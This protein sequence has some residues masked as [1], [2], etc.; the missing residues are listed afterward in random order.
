MAG[1]EVLHQ[2]SSHGPL[3]AGGRSAFRDSDPRVGL[4]RFV[5]P[6]PNGRR[7]AR[8]RRTSCREMFSMSGA[9]SRATPPTKALA[10]AT[11]ATGMGLTAIARA[12]P[13]ALASVV[14]I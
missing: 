7:L 6:Q 8:M 14:F 2:L 4:A 9:I 13:A 5:R 11:G 1:Q 12:K 3:A 10:K